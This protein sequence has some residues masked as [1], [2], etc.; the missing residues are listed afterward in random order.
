M[1]SILFST[2]FN[3]SRSPHHQVS[4]EGSRSCL[5]EQPF[6]QLGEEWHQGRILQ[7]ARAEVVQ[8]TYRAL[9]DAFQ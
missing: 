6:A 4:T 1:E 9:S 2:W 5:T 3:D 8:H 7:H